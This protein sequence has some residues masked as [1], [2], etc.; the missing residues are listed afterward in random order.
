VRPPWH[1]LLL[2]GASGVG[3]TSISYRLAQHYRT[4][5]TEVD[6]FQVILER[7]TT[8]EQH[9]V[10]HFWG[11]HREEAE[12]MSDEEHIAFFLE[13]A[14]ALEEALASVI[15]NHLET[16]MPVILEGDFILPSLAVRALHGD[17]ESSGQVRALFVCEDSEAQIARNYRRR[18]GYEQPQRAHV[19]YRV[20]GWLHAEAKSLGVPTIAAR[21]WTTALSRAIGAIDG[22]T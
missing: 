13:Y 19:S 2:G 5:L 8:P 20:N 22:V 6:D 21:P 3:K 1:V 15:E 17:R 16:R 4:G 18:D 9:P 7:M 11:T 14:A 12:R 10:F